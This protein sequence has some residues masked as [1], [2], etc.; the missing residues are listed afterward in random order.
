MANKAIVA[1]LALF[2]L[3]VESSQETKNM[4][5]NMP[6]NTTTERP[7]SP[8]SPTSPTSSSP[9]T[10]SSPPDPS[11]SPGSTAAPAAAAAPPE[12]WYL[13]V[14]GTSDPCRGVVYLKQDSA[15]ALPVCNSSDKK[16]QWKE[17]CG[18]FHCGDFEKW[19]NADKKEK[20]YLIQNGRPKTN[21]CDFILEIHCKAGPDSKQLAAYKAVTGLL[22][23]VILLVLL[24]KFGPHIYSTVSKRLFGRR[25]REWIGP[26]ESQSVS[27]YR[28]QTGLHP[29]NNTDQRLSFPGLERLTVHSS[30]EP[31]SNRNSD[32]DSYN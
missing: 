7:S 24:V 29:N 16:I 1:F 12:L 20:G 22:C 32:Y 11:P 27:I 15:P 10:P 8:S 2:L 17:L 28:A 14:R 9:S 23:V 18:S 26:T 25:K 6:T 19:G 30:R 13:S 4:T 31:S 21:S 5:I 3:G